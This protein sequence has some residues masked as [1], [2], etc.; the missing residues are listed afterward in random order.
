MLGSFAQL[1]SGDG[2]EVG[3]E[4]SDHTRRDG[5]VGRQTTR[6]DG[7]VFGGLNGRSGNCA[8]RRRR[9][10]GF[11]DTVGLRAGRVN[12]NGV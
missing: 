8:G 2:S 9:R 11:N 3:I 10:E 6:G 1:D 7:R 12:G 5:N 4:D